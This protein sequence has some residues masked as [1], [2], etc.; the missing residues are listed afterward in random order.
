[1]QNN[2]FYQSYRIL[3][4][5]LS[6]SLKLLIPQLGKKLPPVIKTQPPKIPTL[7]KGRIEVTPVRQPNSTGSFLASQMRVG[8]FQPGAAA[9][10]VG[11]WQHPVAGGALE[12]VW[13]FR[14]RVSRCACPMGV[15][16]GPMGCHKS[17][18]NPN[19][20]PS[21]PALGGHS[22]CPFPNDSVH[23][24]GGKKHS[25]LSF[26]AP[27]MAQLKKEPKTLGRALSP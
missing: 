23:T 5:S 13:N 22:Y 8:R 1:M 7:K 11:F 26:G 16:L 2:I 9:A 19:L 14:D 25:E 24:A 10:H 18:E 21:H 15:K 6:S 12:G 4:P 3:P 27:I 17:F 20:A